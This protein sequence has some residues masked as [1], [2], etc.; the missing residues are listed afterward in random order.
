MNVLERGSDVERSLLHVELHVP[1]CSGRTGRGMDIERPG[2]GEQTAER[3]RRDGLLQSHGQRLQHV[4]IGAEAIRGKLLERDVPASARNEPTDAPGGD[5][6]PI[7]GAA[8]PLEREHAVLPV[9]LPP[10]PLQAVGKPSRLDRHRIALRSGLDLHLGPPCLHVVPHDRGEL[11]VAS[12]IDIVP[13]LPDAGGQGIAEFA[14]EHDAGAGQ[15]EG[16]FAVVVAARQ[17][18]AGAPHDPRVVRSR[19]VTNGPVSAIHANTARYIRERIGKARVGHAALR[20]AD[21]QRIG[22]AARQLR[23]PVMPEDK[24]K[25]AGGPQRADNVGAAG[26]HGRQER[27]VDPHSLTPHLQHPDGATRLIRPSRWRNRAKGP[28]YLHWMATGLSREMNRQGPVLEHDRAHGAVESVGEAVVRQRHVAAA[29]GDVWLDRAIAAGHLCPQV[30]LASRQQLAPLRRHRLRQQPFPMPAHDQ[31]FGLKKQVEVRGVRPACIPAAAAQEGR[32]GVRLQFLELKPRT[33]DPECRCHVAHRK[34]QGQVLEASRLQPSRHREV[35]VLECRECPRGLPLHADASPQASDPVPQRIRRLPVPCRQHA[36]HAG[37][38]FERLHRPSHVERARRGCHSAREVHPL[39][40]IPGGGALH[41]GPA[42]TAG[43]LLGLHHKRDLP[44]DSPCLSRHVI[45][46][47]R[48]VVNRHWH[49]RR[50]AGP[51][52][53]KPGDGPAAICLPHGVQHRP[54]ETH[55]TDLGRPCD[56]IGEIRAACQ[57]NLF[58][59]EHLS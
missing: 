31:P 29:E 26:R 22:M 4:M 25:G 6:R 30:D 59:P 57:T 56:Q 41:R 2:H 49:H 8:H 32:A 47:Q 10:K 55:R 50:R 5:G 14:F 34:R 9:Q 7:M 28:L 36:D 53:H 52:F 19:D 43:P 13:D 48:G 44:D 12:G 46:E 24:V 20:Q 23:R 42:S 18:H 1:G 35:C 17:E 39:K 27:V 21:A 58:D 37:R 45:H 11:G 54:A 33:I 15:V 51:A 40:K 38:E 3:D 16:E